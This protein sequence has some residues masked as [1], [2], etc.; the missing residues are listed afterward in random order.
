MKLKSLSRVRPH[1]LQPTRLL[2]PWDFPGKSTGV[3]CHVTQL[4]LILCDPIDCSPPGSSVH[5]ILQAT[6]LEWVVVSFSRV[7]S[8]PRDQTPVSCI[9]GRFFTIWTTRETYI[10]KYT[11]SYIYIYSATYIYIQ[12][13]IYSVTCIYVTESPCYPPET[14]VL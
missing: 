9:A 3:G 8:P 14:I 13:H 2:R 1:G 5:G 12:L 4:C 6:I 11:F 7:S 10:Y